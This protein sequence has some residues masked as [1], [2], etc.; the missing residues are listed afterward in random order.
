VIEKKNELELNQKTKDKG[1]KL[2]VEVFVLEVVP[3]LHF[4]F[5]SNGEIKIIP[6]FFHTIK[7]LI[8]P[9]AQ[10]IHIRK[11]KSYLFFSFLFN[12]IEPNFEF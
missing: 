1:Q 6:Y 5:H 4:W 8:T 12:L 3:I 11:R 9:L 10:Y 2:L 7:E